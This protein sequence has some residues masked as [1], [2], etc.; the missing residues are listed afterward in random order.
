MN[1]G[2]MAAICGRCLAAGRSLAIAMLATVLA[3][4][5]LAQQGPPKPLKLQGLLLDDLARMPSVVKRGGQ[6]PVLRGE[7]DRRQ[8]YSFT[9]RDGSAQEM[10]ILDVKE[11]VQWQD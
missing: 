7:L 3:G 8:P 9:V 5:A 4:G 11:C 10:F 1:A 6:A 2:A